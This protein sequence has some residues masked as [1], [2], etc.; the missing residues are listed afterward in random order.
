M[1]H[2]GGSTVERRVRELAETSIA[3]LTCKE[4]EQHAATIEADKVSGWCRGGGGGRGVP[5]CLPAPHGHARCRGTVALVRL[6]ACVRM[7]SPPDACT[8]ARMGARARSHTRSPG[9]PSPVHLFAPPPAAGAAAAAAAAAGQAAAGVRAAQPAA[10]APGSHAGAASTAT[11]GG[12]GRGRGRRRRAGASHVSRAWGGVYQVLACS[13]VGAG[14][15]PC[16]AP[17]PLAA[18]SAPA[19]PPTTAAGWS[20]PLPLSLPPRGRRMP[21]PLPLPTSPSPLRTASR[22]NW[23]WWRTQTGRAASASTPERACR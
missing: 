10:A 17:A 11:R 6:R 2:I 13:W 4:L 1:V 3:D 12:G 9:G 20:P 16:A 22:A 18:P 5:A 7:R 8:C 21:A 14:P 23:R 15:L 19:A